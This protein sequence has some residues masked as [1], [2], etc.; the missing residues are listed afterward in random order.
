ME[1]HPGVVLARGSETMTH[2]CR[3]TYPVRTDRSV[4]VRRPGASHRLSGITES[5][6]SE[7]TGHK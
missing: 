3:N 1:S 7:F 5:H 2:Y 4:T 6:R